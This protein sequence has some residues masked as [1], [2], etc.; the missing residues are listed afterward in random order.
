[1]GAQPG[2]W[3]D[4]AVDV[5]W[6]DPSWIDLE[7]DVRPE[8]PASHADGADQLAGRHRLA[9]ADRDGR[10]VS[11]E[12]VGAIR[13]LNGDIV[14][15]PPAGRAD[16]GVGDDARCRSVQ[17]CADGGGKV[18]TGVVARPHADLT[19]AG[20]NAVAAGDRQAALGRVRVLS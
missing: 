18:Q 16:P 2:N 17:R 3:I 10:H 11:H 1:M 14:A 5:A 15:S 6:C 19:K 4:C 9:D 20:S 13:V 12:G 8:A 7:V